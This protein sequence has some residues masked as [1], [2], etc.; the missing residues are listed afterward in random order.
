MRQ[1]TLPMAGAM[2]AGSAVQVTECST[3]TPDSRRAP[4]PLCR[5]DRA[6]RNRAGAYANLAR[7]QVTVC[8]G[9]SE[10]TRDPSASATE[11]RTSMNNSP[12]IPAIGSRVT[13][14]C[15]GSAPKPEPRTRIPVLACWMRHFFIA[16]NRLQLRAQ[17][18]E[19]RS[20]LLGDEAWIQA[21][22]GQRA[23]AALASF[24]QRTGIGKSMTRRMVETAVDH[25]D[26]CGEQR[27][28]SAFCFSYGSVMRDMC[29]TTSGRKAKRCP[30][31]DEWHARP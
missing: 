16:R 17:P 18:G 7:R 5:G 25:I 26:A 24:E 15:A 12:Y 23:R 4:A 30:R 9:V 3:S 14:R 22:A 21:D 10:A 11:C 28:T 20:D 29:N 1:A 13:S 19:Q 27:T 2:H 31:S 6:R 8:S